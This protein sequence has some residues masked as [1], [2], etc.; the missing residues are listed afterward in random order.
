MNIPRI[1]DLLGL[2]LFIMLFYYFYNIP[3]IIRTNLE[4]FL[5]VLTGI[6]AIIDAIFFISY[7]ISN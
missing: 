6:A 2:I 5:L 3:S 1:A 7:L 4:T